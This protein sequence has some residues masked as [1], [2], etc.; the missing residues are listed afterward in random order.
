MK[1]DASHEKIASRTVASFP[2]PVQAFRAMT[3]FT[4]SISSV[5]NPG[6]LP[7]ALMYALLFLGVALLGTRLVRV[8]AQHSMQH[9]PD[10]TAIHFIAQ[11]LQVGIFLVMLIFY[12][13]LVPVLRAVGTA[14]L[15]GVSVASIV[16]GLAAQSTLG[17]LIA[18]LALLLYR[19]FRLGD[20]V[21][22]NTPKGVV[23]GVIDALTLGY[24]VLR[25]SAEEQIIVPNSVM[26][27]VIII[28]ITPTAPE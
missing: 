17:N 26:A 22:L 16:I 19:P 20:Q 4:S 9:V 2:I 18:G 21:Q 11:L 24:T 27:S 28:R 25:I 14:L 6:T 7:G 3:V 1:G 10:R 5:F 12:A 23:T 8:L 13:H 15:T